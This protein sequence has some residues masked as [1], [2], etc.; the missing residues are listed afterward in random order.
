MKKKNVGWIFPLV[1]FAFFVLTM[2]FVGVQQ[3]NILGQSQIKV[4]D[5][6]EPSWLI[7]ASP[8]GRGETYSFVPRDLAE[9]PKDGGVM[10][11]KTGFQVRFLPVSENYCMYSLREDQRFTENLANFFG[12]TGTAYVMHNPIMHIPLY[13]EF[14]KDGV[15]IDRKE[16]NGAKIGQVY[17]F[18]DGQGG[19]V[20]MEF[21]GILGGNIANPCP[22]D[23]VLRVYNDGRFDF[24]TIEQ[25]V[26][27]FGWMRR[28]HKPFWL[29]DNGF[30]NAE[31]IGR[32]Q[33]KAIRPVDTIG[34]AT[35]VM[36]ANAKFLDVVYYPPS[37]AVPK[38]V[39]TQMPESFSQ[40]QSRGVN[41]RVRNDGN[42]VGRIVTTIDIQRGGVVSG[43][44]SIARDV[45][46]G[47]TA[48]FSFNIIGEDARKYDEV[49]GT[50]RS[51]SNTLFGYEDCDVQTFRKE[52]VDDGLRG[53]NNDGVCQPELGETWVNC[54]ADCERP[55][56]C[57]LPNESF[58]N[59][60][61]L[62]DVGF[63][64]SEDATGRTYCAP[65]KTISDTTLTVIILFVFILINAVLIGV[66]FYLKK[67]K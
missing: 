67:K 34:R 23:V 8:S 22:T 25:Y 7:F 20:S 40:S 63:E 19:E 65:I 9:F 46:R 60:V 39:D 12:G 51:C 16:V 24:Y 3:F 61:C 28:N 52:L 42:G 13:V 29:T 35:V 66:Y 32:T 31:L 18:S 37:Q 1:L 30:E 55:K 15:V 26:Q 53:C 44:N 48:L 21:T 50:I 49:V 36:T 59:G 27:W 6:G 38:I 57:D 5:D 11:P 64:Y 47:E 56:S 43:D 4:G 10:I 41:V 62:C 58:Y 45:E 33:F 2:S 14:L 17:H 54:P